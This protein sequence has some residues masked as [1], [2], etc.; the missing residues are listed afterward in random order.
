MF[1]SF[2]NIYIS[3]VTL[4]LKGSPPPPTD[5]LGNSLSVLLISTFFVFHTTGR[6][7]WYVMLV[8]NF[9]QSKQAGSLNL[10]SVSSYCG[11]CLVKF[12]NY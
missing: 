12:W 9:S 10:I 4:L 7:P 8:Q 11:L 2:E 1:Y 5:S 3:E 6:S